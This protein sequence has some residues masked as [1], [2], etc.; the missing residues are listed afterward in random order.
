MRRG[1]GYDWSDVGVLTNIGPDHIGQDGIETVEDIVHI[2]SLVAERVREGGTLVLN[3]DDEHLA[4]LTERRR[5][6]APEKKIVYFSLDSSNP[7]VVA[8]L[9]TGGTAYYQ[10]DGWIVEATGNVAHLFIRV[11]DI[12]VTMNGSAEFQVANL[13]AAAEAASGARRARPSHDS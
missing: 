4:R 1:L 13:M 8:H 10:K 7:L 2:K 5:V 3:A 12:P 11:N 9:E 6:R